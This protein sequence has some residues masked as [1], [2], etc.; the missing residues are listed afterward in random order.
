MPC[1][2]RT[3]CWSSQPLRRLH[4]AGGRAAQRAHAGRVPRPRPAPHARPHPRLQRRR[5]AGAG[6][7]AAPLQPDRH[8][9]AARRHGRR[10]AGPRGRAR[11]GSTCRWC[12]LAYDNR[13]L[14]RLRGAPRHRAASSACFLWQGDARILLAIVKY[15]E[16]Q[17]NVAHDTRS[18]RRAGHPAGRGQRPLLLVVPADDLHRADPPVPAPD[19]ARAINLSHKLVRMRARPKILLCTTFEEAWERV[20]A[21][22]RATCWASSPTSSSRAAAA[23]RREAGFE[24]ARAR[25]RGACP[26][27]RSCSSR[28]GRRTPSAARSVGAAF[29]LK[30]S[31]TLLAR[32]APLHGRALRLRRLRLPPART[33]PRSTAPPTCKLARGEAAHRAGREHRLPRRAQPLLELAQG[34]HRVRAGP[35]AAAAQ[36]LRLPERRGAAPRPDR[37]RSPTTGAS[38]AQALVADFD[39]DD[40]RPRP[41]TSSASAAA[42]WAARRAGSPSCAGCWP[43]DGLRDRLS[44]A[45]RSPCPPAVVLATDVFDRFL[46]ENDLRD[47]ALECDGRRRRSGAAS[48]P[49]ASPTRPG[50]TWRR[51]CERARCPLAVRSSSLLEDSQYQPLHRRLRDLHAAQQR[52]PTRASGCAQAARARSSASTPRPSPGT[53]RRYLR[54]TPYRL[55]EEKMAV[56]LQKVVGARARRPLLPRLLRAWRARTTSTRRRRSRSEDGVAAVALGP[57][58]H[59]GRGRELPALLPALP[60]A[61][62]CSS[63]RCTDML[64][65]SQ[66]EFWALELAA[67]RTAPTRSMREAP[68]D[69]E[70]AEADGTLRAV[71]LD[72]LARERR[73]LRRARRAPGARLVTLRAGAQ[74]RRLPARRD[75][76][77]CCSSWAR[78]GMKRPVEIEFAVDLRRAPGAPQRVRLP[79]D[80]PAGAVARDGGARDRRGRARP[81]CCA[82]ARGCSGN[83]TDRAASATSWWWTSSASTARAAARPPREVAR[84]NAELLAARP[85][86]PADRRRA[87]GLDRPLARHPG[88]LGR[89]SRARA[90]SSRPGFR[91]F[92]VDAL[93]GQPLL[94]EPDL[95]PGRLLHGQPRAGRGLRG[96]GLARR[97][98][99]RLGAGHV[100]HLRL[101][102]PVLVQMN[103]KTNEGVILKPRAS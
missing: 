16:D 52:T 60:A 70:V 49:R 85:P 84:F 99:G 80:A 28:R 43:S 77:G 31:P 78:G 33:A 59:G 40:L 57:R 25:A 93:A 26:T 89:R 95:V 2:V 8:H 9:A 61:P 36:G 50:A 18:G 4:P 65:N 24:L 12:V 69:L 90:S 66:R 87:L 39:R 81:R 21:L 91:D 53:R 19:L 7:R 45:S 56:I 1:R 15:I 72:L 55:E 13:E 10:R 103:G 98:A 76:R 101:A 58:P 17:R 64:A 14:E 38:G 71:G 73:G 47:F 82:A 34:P 67:R 27:C 92:R 6:S 11:P 20:L 83:G 97:P 37:R 42:R 100:R 29:L 35:R 62:R 68:F 48:W 3:S 22:P 5:G 102:E 23:A 41:A 86:V 88:H 51:S 54:A 44:R 96:L 46:D 79:A 94:P 75:P 30:G 32:P 63:P 74:A